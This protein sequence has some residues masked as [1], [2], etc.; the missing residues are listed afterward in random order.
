MMLG[1]AT[2]RTSPAGKE[3]GCI[4]QSPSAGQKDRFESI[5]TEISTK[6]IFIVL[7]HLVERPTIWWIY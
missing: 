4:C 2:G 3:V 7:G 5:E 6:S 1:E